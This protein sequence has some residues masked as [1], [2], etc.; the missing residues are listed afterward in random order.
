MVQTEQTFDWFN[1]EI[2]YYLWGR[3]RERYVLFQRRGS[4]FLM[5][6]VWCACKD[7]LS[8][9]G[10]NRGGMKL[11]W[12][13]QRSVLK[14]SHAFTIIKFLKPPSFDSV[15]FLRWNNPQFGFLRY[16][17]TMP[18]ALP[19]SSPHVTKSLPIKIR[20]NPSRPTLTLPVKFIS[21]SIGLL[22]P[23]SALPSPPS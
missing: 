21:Q 12:W 2:S 4:C 18:V 11:L 6:F 22:L 17:S 5:P 19:S 20:S 9:D 7:A 13:V 8:H 10:W 15:L 23:S 14:L 1:L 16:F 3:S